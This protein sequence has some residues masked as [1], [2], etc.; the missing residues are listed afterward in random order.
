MAMTGSVLMTVAIALERYVNVKPSL[1]IGRVLSAQATYSDGN[2]NRKYLCLK[3]KLYSHNSYSS[4]RIEN[5]V[6]GK[7]G[8]CRALEIEGV[9]SE[10]DWFCNVGN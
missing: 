5:V 6:R 9:T 8:E 2:Q 1:Y 10:R 3:R 7:R 4:G